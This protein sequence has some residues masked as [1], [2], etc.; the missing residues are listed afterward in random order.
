MVT[1]M[2]SSQTAFKVCATTT[3]VDDENHFDAAMH[4]QEALDALWRKKGPFDYIIN[5][6]GVTADQIDESSNDSV[7]R[8]V[9]LNAL[10][11]HE[12]AEWASRQGIRGIHIST[13]GVFSGRGQSYDEM[14]QHDCLDVYGKTKSLGEVHTA[15][16]FNLRCSIIGPSPFYHRGLMEWFLSQ[17][18][19]GTVNGFT[20]EYWNGVTTHQ[21]AALIALIIKGDRFDFL[22]QQ[23]SVFH[24]APFTAISKYELLKILAEVFERQISVLAAKSPRG[25]MRRILSSRYD[26]LKTIASCGLS[27]KEEI[28]ILKPWFV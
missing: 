7:M 5:C 8:S 26:H 16:F 9:R 2:L 10:F 20:N 21:L 12:L 27:L 25:R 13:D 17:P 18:D 15:N 23:S 19:G 1:Q 6:I 11:P 14:A 24:F 28:A 3:G 4:P 22:R